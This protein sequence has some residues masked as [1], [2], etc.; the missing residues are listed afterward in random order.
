[1]MYPLSILQILRGKLKPVWV[2]GSSYEFSVLYS[3]V[4]MLRMKAF[5]ILLL[6]SQ[7]KIPL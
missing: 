4:R 2:D 1:M 3:L 5:V 6:Q 7:E